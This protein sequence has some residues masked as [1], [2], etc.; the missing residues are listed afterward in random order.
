MRL[1]KAI[2]LL[3]DAKNAYDS[4]TNKSYMYHDTH[5]DKLMSELIEARKRV[6]KIHSKQDECDSN[7]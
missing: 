1:G 5:E 4:Y 6:N 2:E 3:I 7:K